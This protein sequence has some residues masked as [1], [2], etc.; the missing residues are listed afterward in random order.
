MTQEEAALEAN[1]KPESI[2]LVTV[3]TAIT[4]LALVF[5]QNLRGNNGVSRDDGRA[6]SVQV[7]KQRVDTCGSNEAQTTQL[8]PIDSVRLRN[9]ES[10]KII[11]LMC[12]PDM[13]NTENL[14]PDNHVV[15][16][17]SSL[18]P[19]DNPPHPRELLFW[20]QCNSHCSSRSCPGPPSKTGFFGRFRLEHQNRNID[21]DRCMY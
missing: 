12:F 1:P 14:W 3:Y 9:T 10:K 7:E 4:A 8:V 20:V 11:N 13:K 21:I 2:A 16:T 18:S 15:G 5:D 17:P 6:A 19:Q